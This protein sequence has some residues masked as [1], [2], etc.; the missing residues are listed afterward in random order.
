MNYSLTH[1][2]VRGLPRVV[3]SWNSLGDYLEDVQ[4]IYPSVTKYGHSAPQ[5]QKLLLPDPKITEKLERFRATL[6]RTELV[7][8]TKLELS[9]SDGTLD[10]G[11]YLSGEPECFV[12]ITKVHGNDVR[13]VFSPEVHL[14]S[15]ADAL[16]LRGAAIL[17]LMDSLESSGN[18]VELYMGWDNTVGSKVYESRILVKRTCD[19][20]TAAQLAGI[21]C[22]RS[23]LLSCEYN[24]IAHFLKTG[25]VGGNHGL[26]IPGDIV[27]SGEYSEMAHFDS[28]E[29]TLAWIETMKAKLASRDGKIQ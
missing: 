23:F 27:I 20:A 3:A 21:A 10:V 4:A 26:S 8:S 22:D 29:S 28:T 25:G 19:Y 12:K 9:V 17:S 14:S 15:N 11:L 1:D 16:Y 2:I 13:I 24:M 5:I 18:R 7:K 6:D